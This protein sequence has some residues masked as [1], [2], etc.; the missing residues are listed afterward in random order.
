MPAWRRRTRQA[1]FH[2]FPEQW[3]FNRN[4]GRHRKR[5]LNQ[6]CEAEYALRPTQA[7]VAGR[8]A[9]AEAAAMAM[10]AGFFS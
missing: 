2:K 9:P 6:A 1:P 3:L 8:A 4:I 10:A 7:A 5:A